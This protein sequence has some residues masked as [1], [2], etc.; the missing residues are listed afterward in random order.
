MSND[1][2]GVS[3]WC[4]P[5][6]YR[7]LQIL[8]DGQAE[9]VVKGSHGTVY[10]CSLP[11]WLPLPVIEEMIDKFQSDLVNI[12]QKAV[13]MFDIKKWGHKRNPSTGSHPL[14]SPPSSDKGD[15][16]APV[17]VPDLLEVLVPET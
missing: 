17:L 9:A 14:S 4:C 16:D 11:D 2:I 7:L 12:L 6:C 15:E 5:V 3:K 13:T 8:Y 10:A 1:H